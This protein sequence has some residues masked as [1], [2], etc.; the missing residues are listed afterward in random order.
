MLER[1]NSELQPSCLVGTI[2]G[3]IGKARGCA[4]GFQRLK[5]QGLLIVLTK[6][7]LDPP[8]KDNFPRF[9]HIWG[10][11]LERLLPGKFAWLEDQVF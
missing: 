7:A 6:E 1:S 3:A 2:M 10:E 8:C 5:F 11:T 4:D 9:C